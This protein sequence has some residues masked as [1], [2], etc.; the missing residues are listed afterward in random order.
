MEMEAH[1]YNLGAG[2]KIIPAL[3]RSRART[4]SLKHFILSESSWNE[5]WAVESRNWLKESA[6]KY[7]MPQAEM[8]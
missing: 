5:V 1:Y 2:I 4:Y 7:K 3:R 6:C 8:G